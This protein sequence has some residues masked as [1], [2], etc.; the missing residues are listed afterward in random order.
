HLAIWFRAALTALGSF[1]RRIGLPLID[2]G[3]I[4][5]SFW[6]MKNIWGN[7]V[8]PDIHYDYKLLWIAFPAYT[9]FYL[10]TAYYAGLYDKRYKRSELVGSSVVSIIVLLAG[11][12]LL[13]EQYRFSRAIVLFGAL[14]AFMLISI[15][16]WLLIRTNV[17]SN[18]KDKEEVHHTVIAGTQE[19]YERAVQILND[20]SFNQRILGRVAVESNDFSAIGHYKNLSALSAALPLREVIYCN[21]S[22]LFADIIKGISELPP[23]INAKIHAAGSH[24]IVGSDSKDTSGESVSK[25]NGFKLAEPRYRRLKRLIDVAV[26]LFALISFPIQL[27]IVKKPFSF[28]KNCVLILLGYKTWI[29]YAT[30]EKNIPPLR[31]AVMACNGVAASTGQQLPAESL[32]MLDYWYARDYEPLAELKLIGRIYRRLGD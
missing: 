15:L 10:I 23:G 17:I 24:S 9:I 3:L 18:N 28:L 6:L 14:L 1:I 11:Y 32:Q 16:R 20:A 8:R 29:G 31:P 19:E 2:A 22:L 7:Y 4:L 21:G 13:P 25:E 30:A 27:L 5:V 26:A 12:A